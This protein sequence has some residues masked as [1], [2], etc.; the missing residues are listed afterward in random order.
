LVLYIQVTKVGIN[1]LILGMWGGHLY[2]L[3]LCQYDGGLEQGNLT[4]HCPFT[5]PTLPDW[6]RNLQEH[7]GT[8]TVK[9]ACL[10]GDSVPSQLPDSLCH[11]SCSLRKW[12]FSCPGL[13]TDT[14]TCHLLE[15]ASRA[16]DALFSPV[17]W[18]TLG[19]NEAV[20]ALG[21]HQGHG[22]STTPLKSGSCTDSLPT[23]A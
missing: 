17:R 9:G 20:Y 22:D 18:M 13:L 10:P 8:H 14:N 23:L 1:S 2:V 21:A 16:G 19:L 3:R 12:H 7:L 6:A 4:T 5:E 11:F 15:T